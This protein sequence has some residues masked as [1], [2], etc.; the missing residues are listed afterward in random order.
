MMNKTEKSNFSVIAIRIYLKDEHKP[1]AHI[2]FSDNTSATMEWDNVKE[3]KYL[4]N[5]I[6]AYTLFYDERPKRD[7]KDWF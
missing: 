4:F 3:R 1:M 6:T 2:K 7:F 5:M